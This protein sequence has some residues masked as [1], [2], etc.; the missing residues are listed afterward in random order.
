METL[1][2]LDRDGLISRDGRRNLKMSKATETT[3]GKQLAEYFAVKV[4]SERNSLSDPCEPIKWIRERKQTKKD[5]P[6]KEDRGLVMWF[7]F[8]VENTQRLLTNVEVSLIFENSEWHL[9][10]IKL[11]SE[12]Q[13]P[14]P[15]LEKWVGGA[16]NTLIK[17]AP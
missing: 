15:S 17:I 8:W 3:E 9:V 5:W 7:L 14:K 10:S 11:E 2:I 12:Y 16:N 4:M 13:P 6:S 1:A